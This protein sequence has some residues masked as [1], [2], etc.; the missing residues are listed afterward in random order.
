MAGSVRTMKAGGWLEKSLGSKLPEAL[1]RDRLCKTCSHGRKATKLCVLKKRKGATD[2]KK[3]NWCKGRERRG[4]NG[5][6]GPET[7]E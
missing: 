1:P 6:L 5:W 3:K 7:R 4:E 2:V